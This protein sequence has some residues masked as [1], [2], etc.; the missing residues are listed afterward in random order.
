MGRREIS[1][2]PLRAPPLIHP[3]TVQN[4]PD[5]PTKPGPL[6][7]AAIL[8]VTLI[9]IT[10]G[11]LFTLRFQSP[12]P[13]NRSSALGHSAP[14]SGASAPGMAWLPAGS[15]PASIT[16]G[17]AGAAVKVGGFWID[18]TEVTN[19][20]FKKF[21]EAT[22]YVT[23]AEQPPIN[24]SADAAGAWVWTPPSAN[25]VSGAWKFVTGATWLQ[26]EGP[27]SSI[28]GREHHPVVNVSWVDAA[29]YADWAGKRLP[30]LAELEFAARGGFESQE[31]EWGRELLPP[32]RPPANLDFSPFTSQT[33]PRL[34]TAEAGSFPANRF[35]L[36]DL[37]G[38][39][40]EWCQDAIDTDEKSQSI[41]PDPVDSLSGD[42]AVG[43]AGSSKKAVRGGSFTS[44]TEPEF[45]VSAHAFRSAYA[46][47][48]DVGFRCV[49]SAR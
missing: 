9:A 15:L 42:R 11:S 16:N 23:T 7:F 48:S 5:P 32:G 20:Q 47:Y 22:G 37:T 46:A 31:Y 12:R 41:P 25:S 6:L 36:S 27:G 3:D 29:K 35:G 4:P 33:T 45:K 8:G 13:A 44:R 38:N 21:V 24:G 10:A 43:F 2:R 14:R 30:T 26:P 17:V 19:E 39:V 49:R 34:A 1:P 18:R 28:D 40:W